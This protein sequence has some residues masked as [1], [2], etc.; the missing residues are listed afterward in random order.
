MPTFN[1]DSLETGV[2]TLIGN[3]I[4]HASW[5]TCRRAGWWFGLT[6]FKGLKGRR[7]VAIANVQRAFPDLSEA[8]ARQ[9]ARRSV[10]NSAMMLFEFMRLATATPAEV[11][12][13]VD[14]EGIENI[15]DGLKQG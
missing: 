7:K 3:T 4:Q 13:Y 9:I 8:A 2:T 6:L 10:Q 14:L 11:R 5:T 1:R 12:E 15:F